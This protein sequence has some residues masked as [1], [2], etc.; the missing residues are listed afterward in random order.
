MTKKS[1]IFAHRGYSGKFPENTMLSFKQAAFYHADGIELDVHM[2]KDNQLVVCHDET[3]NRTSDG[4]GTI[5]EMTLE[6]LK[7][8][9]FDK[10]FEYLDAEKAEITIPTLEEV[11][12]WILETTLLLNI[13]IKNNIY[14]YNGIIEQIVQLIEK[15]QCLER[16]IVSSFN[17]YTIRQIKYLN[18]EIVCGF[19]T[20]SNILDIENYCKSNGV[21]YYHPA[22]FTLRPNEIKALQKAGIGI[23]PYTLNSKVEIQQALEDNLN[24]IITN[25]VE[26][27]V[28]LKINKK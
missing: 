21:E 11:L 18:E 2:T 22:Y 5:K 26:L 9:R 25:E 4:E 10:G 7:Q 12:S 19:L 20:F 28:A 3:I 6:E 8:Y 24:Y 1:K 27:G 15:H 17:H 23:N 14:D 16:V 13:E